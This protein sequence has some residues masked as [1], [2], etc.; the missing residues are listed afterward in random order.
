MVPVEP[1][2]FPRLLKYT[3]CLDDFCVNIFL[4]AP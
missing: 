4:S 1:L 3:Y 2:T